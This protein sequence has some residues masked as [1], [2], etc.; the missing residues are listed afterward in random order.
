MKIIALSSD[1]PGVT[2]EQ[3][4]PHLKAEALRAWELYLSGILREI[5][6]R[7]DESSAV[8]IL[9]CERVEAAGEILATL[10]LVQEGLIAFELIPLAP[11]PGFA[12]LFEKDQD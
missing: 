10:P 3:F 1:V 8:L 9:E 12:R 6:F 2:D 11:Y 4:P 7:A 5:H